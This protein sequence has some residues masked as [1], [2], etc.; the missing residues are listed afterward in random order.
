MNIDACA[1]HMLPG[2]GSLADVTATFISADP[3]IACT[4]R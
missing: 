1:H 2:V 4:E 3:C